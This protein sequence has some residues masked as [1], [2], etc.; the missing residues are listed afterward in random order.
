M[1]TSVASVMKSVQ[2]LGYGLDNSG[3]SFQFQTHTSSYSVS[4]MVPS[5]RSEVNWHESDQSPLSV[6]LYLHS[7]ASVTFLGSFV[8]S[9]C[10]CALWL[11]VWVQ[12]SQDRLSW[13]L[14]LGAKWKTLHWEVCVWFY[15]NT[16]CFVS[17]QQHVATV[18][19]GY[20]LCCICGNSGYTNMPHC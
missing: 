13:N 19:S 8:M 4:R 9:V 10:P 16:K 7:C 14:I 20:V 1:V 5:L 11:C 6:E 3:F 18:Q 2:L 17:Q 12:L 15:S